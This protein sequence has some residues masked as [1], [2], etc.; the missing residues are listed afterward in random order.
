[1][2]LTSLYLIHTKSIFKEQSKIRAALR[3]FEISFLD[4]KEEVMLA[5]I[6]QNSNLE[7]SL[8]VVRRSL[9]T[10]IGL[11]CLKER[12]RNPF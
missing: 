3:A 1:M 2:F 9:R 11:L 8:Y 4:Y 7:H 5:K 10:F 6:Q 12:E